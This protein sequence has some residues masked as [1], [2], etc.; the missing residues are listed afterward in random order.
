MS[1]FSSLLLIANFATLVSTYN[2][3]FNILIEPYDDQSPN[4][5]N[6]T[7]TLRL[8]LFS[9]NFSLDFYK[10]F[11]MFRIDVFLL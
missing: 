8:F 1:E 4:V 6:P 5:Y 11:Y 9:F 3:G 10:I 2:D 7:L